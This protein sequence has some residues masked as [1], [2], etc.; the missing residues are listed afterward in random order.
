M[1]RILSSQIDNEQAPA[2]PHAHNMRR[3]NND[4]EMQSKNSAD[5]RNSFTIKNVCRLLVTFEFTKTVIVS[6]R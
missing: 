1:R 5:D 4:P 2:L 3:S 6:F